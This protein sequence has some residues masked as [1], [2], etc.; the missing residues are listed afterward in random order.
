MIDECVLIIYVCVW[1]EME[2]GGE[3]GGGEREGER[4]RERRE[5]QT[6]DVDGGMER[7]TT[8]DSSTNMRSVCCCCQE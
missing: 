7:A 5:R 6:D 3:G 2:G 1:R 4:E 8:C